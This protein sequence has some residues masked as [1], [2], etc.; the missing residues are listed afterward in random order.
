MKLLAF[1][2]ETTG[3]ASFGSDQPFAFSFCD[4]DGDTSYFEFPVDP[5]SRKV[6][7]DARPKQVKELR[8]LLADRRTK[9]ICHNA[10]FDVAMCERNGFPVYGPRGRVIKT[11]DIHE[12]IFAAHACRNVEMSYGL[13][14]LSKKYLDIQDEDATHLKKVCNKLRNAA[15]KL[16]WTVGVEEIDQPDGTVKVKPVTES[17]YWLGDT[18]LHRKEGPQDVAEEG[19]AACEEYARLDAYR[20]MCLYLFYAERMNDPEQV[21]EDGRFSSSM[22]YEFEMKCWPAFYAMI[23]RGFCLDKAKAAEEMERWRS[24]YAECLE[25]LQ[26]EAW[27][28]FNPN[29]AAQLAEFLFSNSHCGMPVQRMTPKGNP[30][31]DR[32]ALEALPESPTL[33]K[34]LRLRAAAKAIS[35]FYGNYLRVATPDEY[36]HGRVSINPGFRQVGPATGRSACA[37]PNIQQAASPQTSRNKMVVPVRTV[38]VP[39]PSHWL[40]CIDYSNQEMRV[41]AEVAEEAAMVEAF[42]QGRDVHGEVA[43]RI[44]WSG[45]GSLAFRAI[46]ESLGLDGK[47]DDLL[48][49]EAVVVRKEIDV[50]S[51]EVLPERRRAELAEWWLNKHGKDIAKAEKAL[52]HKRTRAIAK[53]VSFLKI[54]GGG[55]NRL[56]S[57][58]GIDKAHARW[59]LNTYDQLFPRVPQF[60]RELERQAKLEGAVWSLWGRRLEIERGFEY[61]CVNYVVQG[62]SADMVKHA[63]R[64]VYRWCLENEVEVHPLAVVHDEIVFEVKRTHCTERNVVTVCRMMEDMGGRTEVP[65]LVEPSVAKECWE[66]KKGWDRYD[67]LRNSK[68]Y[69]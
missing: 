38:L 54:Y 62:S 67:K 28:G 18:M 61:R 65:M 48:T 22:I 20:T 66:F 15:K 1:D 2:T 56:A 39:R 23:R 11:G 41:F 8:K 34:L 35:S 58:L 9:K 64:N 12:T 69:L 27:P 25:E 59:I 29:S 16:G 13:K 36:A 10:V 32:E 44:W 45:D 5:V 42:K 49:P 24:V 50:K 6:L 21:S 57:F 53:S 47:Q 7:Y 43:N 17:D 46:E 19:R 14:P 68:R 55:A 33:T 63:L 52:G 4:E 30:A 26:E 40:L 51:G 37:S 31:T 3:L 60:A